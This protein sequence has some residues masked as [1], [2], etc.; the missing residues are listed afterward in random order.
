[1]QLSCAGM[2]EAEFKEIRDKRNLIDPK[3]RLLYSWQRNPGNCRA[4]RI[5]G[6]K[7]RERLFYLRVR[8]RA[9][10]FDSSRG[11][12]ERIVVLKVG[13]S[14][15]TGDRAFRRV[16][17][18]SKRRLEIAPKERLVVVVSAEKSATDQLER[19][20]RRLV[21]SPDL[22]ALDLLW[23]TAELRSV[24]L[25]ALHLEAVGV[26]AVGLNVHE[27]GLVVS[28]E[29]PPCPAPPR[30][31]GRH[32]T[33]ELARHALVIVPGFLATRWDGAIVSLGRGGSDFSAVL[34]AVG[35]GAVRCELLKDV[36]GYFE[37]D[38]HANA[39]A[40][41]LPLLSFDE[42]IDMAGRGCELVQQRALLVAKKAGLSLVVRSLDDRAPQ[43]LIAQKA[44]NESKEK[45][46]DGER[47]EAKL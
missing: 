22:R 23:S 11:G 33:E 21:A 30:F 43:S 20:A 44:G 46:E 42:A 9:N 28:A 31:A 13:G 1:L 25:L 45:E 12:D 18:V 47:V 39:G 8:E 3:G 34:L 27:T 10:V 7:R 2:R 26:L 4:A 19:R 6:Y 17:E 40:R 41:H 35:L 14:V 16:A 5:F 24:A 37:A 32:L 36:P 38:P 29:D 15:L